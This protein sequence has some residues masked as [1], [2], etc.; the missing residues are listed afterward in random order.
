[1]S[2]I[3]DI[4]D[5]IM[6]LCEL[7]ELP[8]LGAS[9]AFRT[10]QECSFTS[11][12]LPAFIVQEVINTGRNTRISANSYTMQREFNIIMAL[13]PI[14]SI[15]AYEQDMDAKDLASDCILTVTDF[16]MENPELSL[17]DDAGFPVQSEMSRD[18]APIPIAGRKD[19]KY[20]GAVFRL[21]VAIPRYTG[22]S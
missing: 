1:M 15:E 5:R 16:F 20:H 11:T 9:H 22:R 6:D 7:I 13:T 10:R 21:V 17:N 8:T 19:G 4:R 12:D 14:K 3:T 2:V 18:S